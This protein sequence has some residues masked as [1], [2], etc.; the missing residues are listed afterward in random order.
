ME[1]LSFM[2]IDPPTYHILLSTSLPAV[3]SAAT[4]AT[5]WR[6]FIYSMRISTKSEKRY[7]V[8]CDGVGRV[9]TACMEEG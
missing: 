5:S 8:H 3:L 9:I 7:L 1:R 4:W 6:Y 2:T